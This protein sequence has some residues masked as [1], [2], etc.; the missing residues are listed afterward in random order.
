MLEQ[1]KCLNPECRRYTTS[2][3]GYCGYCQNGFART[4][5]KCGKP[6]RWTNTLCLQ[7]RRLIRPVAKILEPRRRPQ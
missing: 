2:K 4:C 3:T 1:T 5:A 7:C 6:I